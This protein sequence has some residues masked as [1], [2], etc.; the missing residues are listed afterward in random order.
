MDPSVS[1]AALDIDIPAGIDNLVDTDS[2]E[3]TAGDT[4]EDMA[5]V[6]GV[7]GVRT[8]GPVGAFAGQAL[9]GPC[10]PCSLRRISGRR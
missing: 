5:R 8:E 4:E 2:L 9:L 10:H 3:D 6:A 1:A 7:A